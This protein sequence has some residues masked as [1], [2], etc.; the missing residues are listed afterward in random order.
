MITE[1]SIFRTA[2]EMI[3]MSG[4]DTAKEEAL[5]FANQLLEKRDM[6]GRR[7]WLQVLDAIEE[8]QHPH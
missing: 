1:Q 2:D 7:V 5:T 6:E 4:F 3:R 8:L